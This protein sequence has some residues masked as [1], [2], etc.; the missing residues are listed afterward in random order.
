MVVGHDSFVGASIQ[1]NV[2]EGQVSSSA[3]TTFRIRPQTCVQDLKVDTNN[4]FIKAVIYNDT[5][6]A[7][8][9]SVE[10]SGV[11]TSDLS[12]ATSYDYE[13]DKTYTTLII[14]K[15]TPIVASIW[16][17]ISVFTGR[18]YWVVGK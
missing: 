18:L 9:T 17:N 7:I 2:G 6:F 14:M 16:L 4:D 12:P 5:V 8:L 3:S 10:L 13:N 1:H 11:F 15:L